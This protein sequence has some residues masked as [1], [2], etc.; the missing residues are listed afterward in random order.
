MALPSIGE[1]YGRWTVV[2]DPCGPPKRRSVRCRCNC[3]QEREVQVNNLRSGRSTSCGCVRVEQNK[4]RSTHGYATRGANHP[5]Y[6]LW[7]DIVK[8]CTNP[9]AQNY[10]WY[11]GRG[12]KICRE[13]RN[14]PAAFIEWVEK[15]LGNRP[16]GH[17]ID[18]IDPAGDYEPGNLRWATHSEQRLNQRRHDGCG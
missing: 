10:P 14:D 15:N 5:L 6:R 11:G 7:G 2:G 18:R 8:R 17:S 12:V 3:G 16:S 9:N 1:Q 13:W 4:S